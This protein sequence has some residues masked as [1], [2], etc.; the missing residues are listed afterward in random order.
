MPALVVARAGKP[1][2]STRRAETASHTFA[3]T[4]IGGALW[5]SR[6]RA[7]LSLM[8]DAGPGRVGLDRRPFFHQ[9]VVALVRARADLLIRLADFAADVR[10]LIDEHLIFVRT[11][12]R[13]QAIPERLQRRVAPFR[14]HRGPHLRRERARLRQAVA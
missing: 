11:G 4:R 1:S 10:E 8:S 5:S 12:L 3:R 14:R 7:A 2:A 6:R 13:R 9:L